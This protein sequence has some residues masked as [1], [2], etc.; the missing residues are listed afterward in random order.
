[1]P[2]EPTLITQ[3]LAAVGRGEPAALDRLGAEVYDE[4]HRMAHAYMAREGPGRTLQPTALVSEAWLRLAAGDGTF[5]N[6]RHFFGA[7]AKAM[8]RILVDDARRRGCLKRGG[9]THRRMDAETIGP[10]THGSRAEPVISDG[11]PAFI[12]AMDEALATLN[13]ERPDL[14]ELVRLRFFTGLTLDETAEVLGVARRT[15]VNQWRLARALLYGMLTDEGASAAEGL[16]G[17]RPLGPD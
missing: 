15:V 10:L 16:D 4:L 13:A 9:H 5:E 8:H 7:A 11:D 12:L 3:L 14:A 2:G 1:M 17:S 6:R